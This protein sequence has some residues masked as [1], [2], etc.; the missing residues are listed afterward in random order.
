M[1]DASYREMLKRAQDLLPKR[2][3]KYERFE[4]PRAQIV[5]A[6]RKT[7]FLNFKEVCDALNRD[8]HLLLKFLTKEMATLASIDGGRAVF[9]GVFRQDSI[10]NLLNTYIQRYVV[11]PVCKR[12]D[13]RIVKEKRLSFLVC[14][15]C[16]ARS[17]LSGKV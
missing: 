3:E 11:C 10:A 12:P 2:L 1:S 15:A 6:G 13:T 14:E 4:V 9:Q 17:S 5:V 7:A 16:G 8:P